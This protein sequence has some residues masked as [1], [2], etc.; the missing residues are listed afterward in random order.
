ME[1]MNDVTHVTLHSDRVQ[2]VDVSTWSGKVDD[3][4]GFLQGTRR[5]AGEATAGNDFD[6]TLCFALF[7][8]V[9]DVLVEEEKEGEG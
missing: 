8:L 2:L 3:V 5:E 6:L 9:W 1:N 4:R 7:G